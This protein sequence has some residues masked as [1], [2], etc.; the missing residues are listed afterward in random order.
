M[1][2]VSVNLFRVATVVTKLPF[3]YINSELGFFNIMK[4]NC[5]NYLFGISPLFSGLGSPSAIQ[6]RAIVPI[7][8]GRDVIAQ[9]QFGEDKTETLSIAA[10]QSLD[11]N[12]RET[13]VLI[14]SPNRNSAFHV[15]KVTLLNNYCVEHLICY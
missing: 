14:L 6:K 13:Q 10:L 7:M 4:M 12:V 5:I 9:S 2:L 11:M 8:K 3:I 15:H 1:Y